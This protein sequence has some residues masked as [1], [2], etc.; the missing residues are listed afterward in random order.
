MKYLAK[1]ILKVVFLLVDIVISVPPFIM[2]LLFI[3]LKIIFIYN[4]KA[5]NKINILRLIEGG[6]LE[7]IYRK[8]GDLK[9]YFYHLI[10]GITNL[11]IGSNFSYKNNFTIKLRDDYILLET[12][13]ISYL[14]LCSYLKFIVRHVSVILKY[15]I[16][17]I[18]SNSP[19]LL[20]II[21]YLLSCITRLPFCVSIHA[22]YEKSE[23]LQGNVIPRILGSIKIARL[24]ERFVYRKAD[25]V[26]P[27]RE[28][29]IRHIKQAGCPEGKIRVFPHSVNLT[30]FTK[31]SKIDVRQKFSIPQEVNIISSVGRFEKENY[32]EDLVQIAINT[33][34]NQN[35]VFFL[36]C[37]NGSQLESLRQKVISSGLEANIHLPG[38]VSHEVAI[39]VRKQCDISICLMAGFSL[40]E[41]CAAGK[42]VIA[43]DV[44]W[45]YELV[46]NEITGYLV[47]EHN[48]NLVVEKIIHLIKNPITA[49]LIGKTAQKLAVQRHSFEFVNKVKQDIYEEILKIKK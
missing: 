44:E 29:M 20:G 36:I 8:Y 3:K 23:E 40:I 12:K 30:P 46:Q 5:D 38:A 49:K 25:L 42:P 39:E 45:H 37:G 10:P 21:A 17:I 6:D 15:K 28:S 4:R 27:I 32:C 33:V 16:S 18:H 43:Y 14:P 1:Q 19:Y 35:N 47:P 34:R 22:D 24:V 41:A 48:I 9:N 2:V 13:K 26:L 7:S 11:V 31:E